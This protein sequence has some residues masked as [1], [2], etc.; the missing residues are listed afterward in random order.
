MFSAYTGSYHLV[1]L[2]FF[3]PSL[4]SDFAYTRLSVDLRQ[5]FEVAPRNI[6]GVQATGLFIDGTPAF[7]KNAE[8]GG[9]SM[10]RGYI[11]GRYNDNNL[12]A[13]QV[14]Y[15]FPIWSLLSGAVFGAAGEVA[16]S[17]NGFDLPNVKLAY[18]G[19]VRFTFQKEERLLLR[20]DYGVAKGSAGLYL[21]AGEAF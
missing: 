5:F 8:L 18:G 2:K 7:H 6:L 13:A 11:Q 4:G 20:I 19:G 10:M 15:R 17:L 1:N 9:T 16:R 21:S 14:E 12:L 3:G